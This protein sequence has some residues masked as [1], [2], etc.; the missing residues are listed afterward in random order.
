MNIFPHWGNCKEQI[1]YLTKALEA[2]QAQTISYMRDLND[3][4]CKLRLATLKK[5]DCATC[6]ESTSNLPE[7]A[8]VE[9]AVNS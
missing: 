7:Y 2:S 3:L 1:E 4:A 6:T 8:A 5:V 9:D